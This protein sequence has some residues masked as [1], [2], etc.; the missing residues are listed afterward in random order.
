MNHAAQDIRAYDCIKD[1]A[2]VEEYIAGRQGAAGDVV[3]LTNDPSYWTPRSHGRITNAH[4][5]RIHQ[6]TAILGT[7]SWGPRTGAGTLRNRESPIELR[8]TYNCHWRD[9]S[10]LPGTRGHF[11]YLLLPSATIWDPV[12]EREADRPYPHADPLAAQATA[13]WSS[14]SSP[15]REPSLERTAGG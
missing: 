8:G 7:R 1:I 14:R 4:E 10:S 5:F 2:R 12:R 9:Y 15:P 3:V 6:G 11:R 13:P